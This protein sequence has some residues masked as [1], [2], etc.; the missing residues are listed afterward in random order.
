MIYWLENF[1]DDAEC[2]RLI[3]MGKDHAHRKSRLAQ[4]TYLDESYKLASDILPSE[5]SKLEAF[6]KFLDQAIASQ[7][8][9]M[10]GSEEVHFDRPA[11]FY[12]YNTGGFY[13]AHSDSQVVK[14]VNGELVAR[15]YVKRDVSSVLYLND[16]FEGGELVFVHQDGQK[17]KITPKRGALLLFKC[18][19][20]YDHYVTKVTGTRYC[21]AN[22]YRTT[23]SLVKEEEIVPYPFSEKYPLTKVVAHDNDPEQSQPEH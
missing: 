14:K 23:P 15:Q 11:N 13:R 2:V 7:I 21:I 4:N 18:D 10:F 20:Q 16:D 5:G 17:S 3:N 9:G 6:I 12:E 1:I 19:W 8:Q 22:W